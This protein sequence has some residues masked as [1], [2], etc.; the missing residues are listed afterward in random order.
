MIDKIGFKLNR[1]I[2]HETKYI[3]IMGAIQ[4]AELRFLTRKFKR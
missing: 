1:I 2:S 4:E 3:C